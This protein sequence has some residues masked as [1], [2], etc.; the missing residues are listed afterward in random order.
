MI[1][2]THNAKNRIVCEDEEQVKIKNMLASGP[3]KHKL[4]SVDST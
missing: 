3:E 4:H 1:T 2:Y